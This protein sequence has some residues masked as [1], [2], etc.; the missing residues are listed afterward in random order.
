[1]TFGRTWS[2]VVVLCAATG[3][4]VM[5]A[6]ATPP[7]KEPATPPAENDR[8][9]RSPLQTLAPPSACGACD[10]K[11]TNREVV[12]AKKPPAAVLL[13]P[14]TPSASKGIPAVL[15]AEWS[16][17]VVAACEEIAV[18]R[19][20]VVHRQA[21]SGPHRLAFPPNEPAIDQRMVALAMECERLKARDEAREQV[22]TNA[23]RM[24][25]VLVQNARLEARL[26]ALEDREAFFENLL[27][28][29]THC[30]AI[31]AKAEAVSEW[32]E[33]RNEILEALMQS[34][35]DQAVAETRRETQEQNKA[36]QLRVIELEREILELIAARAK[37][38][39]QVSALPQPAPT[40]VESD[41]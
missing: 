27:G 38:A 8:L 11:K 10:I 2:I 24:T 16:A 34:T 28:T 9:H 39:A 36:L 41:E 14:P 4:Y 12:P 31:E 5:T 18:P 26:E 35:V 40:A 32:R 17:P 1:M 13:A 6:S 33:E 22:I 15:P 37:P 30:A 23:A 3:L 29:A 19:G 20:Y 21:P 7:V 25:E